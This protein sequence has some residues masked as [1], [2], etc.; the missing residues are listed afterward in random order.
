[1]HASVHDKKFLKAVTHMFLSSL[2]TIHMHASCMD[3]LLGRFIMPFVV[4]Q[5]NIK[6][7]TGSL[8]LAGIRT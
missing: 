7:S 2:Y 8:L 5:L 3:Y 6:S 4:Y 1:M